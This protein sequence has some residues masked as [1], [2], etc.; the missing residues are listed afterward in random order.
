[1]ND[2]HEITYIKQNKFKFEIML[3]FERKFKQMIMIKKFNKQKIKS[4]CS[5]NKQKPIFET[6]CCDNERK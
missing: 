5:S 4:K 3:T 6:F 2:A 1:M